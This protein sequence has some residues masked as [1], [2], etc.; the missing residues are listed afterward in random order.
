M[1]KR[2]IV[3]AVIAVLAAILILFGGTF[4]WQSISQTAL[5]EISASINPGGRLHDD[6]VDITYGDDHIA[7]YETM[8]FN[9]DVYVENF[10]DLA[11]NGVQVFARVRLDEYM[12]FG[13]GA[14][15]LSENGK[16][17]ADDNEAV[18]LVE[19][20]KLEDKSTW[21]PHLYGV[22]GHE[23]PFAKY[24]TWDLDG[25]TVYMPTFN[26]NKD[27]LAADINSYKLNGYVE[28]IADE[29]KLAAAI[30]DKDTAQ[31]G[32]PEVD[33]LA[34]EDIYSII[35]TGTFDE[36]Y[37]GNIKVVNE[38]HYAKET[39]EAGVITMEEWLSRP[40]EKKTGNFW[41]Y[42][43]DG[44]AYWANPIDPDTATGLL[45]D[46]I[47]RTEEIINKDW[48]YAINVVA[49]FITADDMGQNNN[50]GFYDLTEG[51]APTVNAL[52][53]LETIGVEV[54]NTEVAD[55]A[56]LAEAVKNGGIVTL[57]SDID[58]TE[59]LIIESNTVLNMNG[60]TIKNT[61]TI[62]D[63]DVVSSS[64]LIYVS[65]EDVTLIIE[66]G[67]FDAKEDDCYGVMVNTG[68]TLIINDGTYKGNVSAVYVMEGHATIYGGEF[69]IKQ[70]Y[71]SEFG[72]YKFL[73]NCLDDNYAN[74]TASIT[75]CGGTFYDFDPRATVESSEPGNYLAA[76]YTVEETV[77]GNTTV[78][79][80]V[81]A[82]AE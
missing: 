47:Q 55:E 29:E 41:V 61:Q 40:A 25:K 63:D 16:N 44:W 69:S 6:F 64:A 82:L 43:T 7:D 49:Q 54:V 33:E 53:L 17:K 4:A 76:G 28:Y 21:T 79:T 26:K 58:I 57:T 20:A 60:H 42:D 38:A 72:G 18:S 24:W 34:G 75:I 5:N 10:T 9:K 73:M 45:L 19:S 70:T 39:L 1:K 35:E 27:S 14:G 65:G 77:E 80:V 8:T 3:T 48:Y 32:Y 11:S 12:E 37:A 62:W 74:G 31:E 46:G 51:K 15:L 22:D 36:Q 78:Y 59:E 50:T 52:Q 81:S 23:D 67:V 71:G 56:A 68:A 30:Y 13:P 2:K 66:G